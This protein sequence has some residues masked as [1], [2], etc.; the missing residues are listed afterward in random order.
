[1]IMKIMVM[2]WAELLVNQIEHL[3]FT[4]G[5]EKYS[6]HDSVVSRMEAA[7]QEDNEE[8]EDSAWPKRLVYG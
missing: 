5:P 2:D 4:P 7:W 3:T 8:I 1:M 6:K